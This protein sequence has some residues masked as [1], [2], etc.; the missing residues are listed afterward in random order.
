MNQHNYK[1]LNSLI[2]NKCGVSGLRMCRQWEREMVKIAR[3]KEHITFNKR[4]L[5]N[6][7]YPKQAV[8]NSTENSPKYTEWTRSCKLNYIK[9]RIQH[10]KINISKS[11]KLCKNLMLIMSD[12]I[13]RIIL[14]SI[15]DRAHGFCQKESLIYRKRQTK[16]FNKMAKF[17]SKNKNIHDKTCSIDK[18]NW[19]INLSSK[20]FG[21]HEKSIF[22][23][24]TKFQAVPKFINNNQII[25]N[26]EAKL[27]FLIDDKFELEKIRL[28]IANELIKNNKL[29]PN[30]NNNQLAAINRLRNYV[31]NN[32]IIITDSDKGNKTIILNK[33]DYLNKIYE[34]LNDE[35]LYIEIQQDMTHKIADNLV[36][37]LK[38]LKKENYID[39]IIY[40]KLYPDNFSIPE[41]YGLIKIHKPNK[42]ARIICPYFEYPLAKLAR[43]LND[44]IKPT[45]INCEYALVN[46]NVLCQEI[47]NININ[48]NDT[49]FSLDIVNLFT[50]VP[51][52]FTLSIIES[53]L[54]SD[55]DLAHRTKIPVKTIMELIKFSMS[56]VNFTFDNKFYIQK[57]G[58]PMGSNL[59]PIIARALVSYIFENCI[60]KFNEKYGL[61]PKYCR[62][63]VDDSIIILN[64][65]YVDKF[66]NFINEFSS[67]FGNVEFTIEYEQDEILNFL[68]V[69]LIKKQ[70]KI[71]TTVYRKVI[72]SNRYL[73]FRSHHPL[74]N[75]KSVIR[76]F[77]E[78]IFTK[79]SNQD[80]I[81]SD[82]IEAKNI[83][84]N[85]YYPDYLI[86]S[87]IIE[88][89]RKYSL[90]INNK[91]EFDMSRVICLP[92]FK[93]LSE[94][95]RSIL[96][97]YNINVVFKRGSSVRNFIKGK[98]KNNLDKSHV[99]YKL[100]CYDCQSCYIGQTK[101]KT[102]I[103]ID[104]HKS[105]LESNVKQ[106]EIKY[107]H[108]IDYNNP[109][110]CA[111][112]KNV[113]A[114]RILEGI[115]I[116]KHIHD[117]VQ[118]MNDNL[119]IP[120]NLPKIYLPC[121]NK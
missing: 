68:N 17:L 79:N 104:Q 99:V 9:Y 47:K 28:E 84:K 90:N 86:D 22:Q 72:H 8:V 7:V 71:E 69:K 13:P 37:I 83:L 59:S 57:T 116:E 100:N 43:Y 77:I 1:N 89:K 3:A 63:Y 95:L 67:Q 82:L 41:I 49:M 56:N 107:K 120:N 33:Q 117:N 121:I 27:E 87:I 119:N 38:K 92:Y 88:C 16:K 40:K 26:I 75:K 6:Q 21:E 35:T 23:L 29:K 24:D 98:H 15:V 97:P 51:L 25:A 64:S 10:W 96:K 118:L 60:N 45:I 20:T 91:T 102:K 58:C 85:N 73:N 111:T 5:E 50:N 39:Q 105:R 31:S 32:E 34:I 114:R 70:P 66:Y 61:K 44:I 48:K 103:R 46:S 42:P 108:N 76:T 109:V 54:N 74:Q 65:R 36:K 52:E 80:R 112:E 81:E 53:K 18:T 11:E 30:L 19:F 12:K 115:T 14:R 78:D 4:C 93:K 101:K 2:I 110:I 62:F 113:L 55:N 106:H 94:N